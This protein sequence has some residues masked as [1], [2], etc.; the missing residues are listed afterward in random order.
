[1]CDTFTAI[2]YKL[3]IFRSEQLKWKAVLTGSTY[4]TWKIIID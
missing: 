2:L 3:R 1:M 4:C